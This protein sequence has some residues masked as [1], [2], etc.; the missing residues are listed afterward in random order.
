MNA[1]WQT[2]R[3]VGVFCAAAAVVALG[4]V[5]WSGS[6]RPVHQSTQATDST[7]P[8]L[9]T[10]PPTP[11]V[12][13]TNMSPRAYRHVALVPSS[14]P[15]GARFATG[16]RCD[17]VYFLAGR[18]V[19]LATELDGVTTRHVARLF[20]GSFRVISESAL[21]GVPSRARVSPDGRLAAVTVF[22]SGHSYAETG[23]STR[24]SVL[25]TMSGREVAELEQFATLRDGR[26]FKAVDFNFWGLTFAADSD[27]FYATLATGGT[28]YLVEGRLS[29]RRV[30]VL[31]AGVEC[32]SLSPDNRRIAFKHRVDG[33]SAWQVHVLDL[34]TNRVTPLTGESRSVDDQVDWLDDAHVVY[35]MTG[36][37]GADV[38]RLSVDGA[39]PPQLLVPAAYSPVVVR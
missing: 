6:G 24:T 2:G 31:R 23:F 20:D 38:W 26:P 16:L 22:E 32:P 27:R 3:A 33:T 1:R 21:T 25:D 35:H 37:G 15:G 11:F 4:Y 29:E 14:A 5:L 30:R 18:G 34:E 19:C 8:Q 12:M 9:A 7:L 17:R 10:A 13:F 28:S 39:S 36:A